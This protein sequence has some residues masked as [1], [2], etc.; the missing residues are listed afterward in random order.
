MDR[1]G[2]TITLVF[3]CGIGFYSQGA[4][5]NPLRIH[6]GWSKGT[7]STAL[8]MY[9]A[10]SGSWVWWWGRPLIGW[11][12]TSSYSGFYYYRNWV[13]SLEPYNPTLAIVR[14]LPVPGSGNQSASPMTIT[15]LI[16]NWFVCEAGVGYGID[17]ER[18]KPGGNDHVPFT[19]YLIS[20]W[21][22]GWHY[23]SW[24]GCFAW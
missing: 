13:L 10:I 23:P 11:V 16:A 12:Q 2:S 19:V 20:H 9:F 24:G 4:I 15:T 7:I 3:S 18:I 22:P 14:G 8:T 5:F 6:Y 21:G 17:H 1:F